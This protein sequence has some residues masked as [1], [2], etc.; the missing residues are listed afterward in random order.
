MERSGEE[1]RGEEEWRGGVMRKGGDVERRSGE[2]RR[3][4]KEWRGGVMRKGGEE[5]KDRDEG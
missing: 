5:R 3:N 2:E 4:E 1:M